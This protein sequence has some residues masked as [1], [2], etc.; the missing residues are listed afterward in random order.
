[1]RTDS[2]D[3]SRPLSLEVNLAGVKGPSFSIWHNTC[4]VQGYGVR[5]SVL[6]RTSTVP[7]AEWCGPERRKENNMATPTTTATQ[8][9]TISAEDA[10]RRLDAGESATI[11]D[12]RNPKVW[13]SS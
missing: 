6:N 4:V 7:M 11:L 10:K 13:S 5:I 12:V 2:E 1:S 8:T 3:A 9:L